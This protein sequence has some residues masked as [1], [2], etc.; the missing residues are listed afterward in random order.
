[1]GYGGGEAWL[2]FT[3]PVRGQ[4]SL[5]CPQENRG[6]VPLCSF[7]HRGVPQVYAEEEVRHD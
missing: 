6:D 5:T 1:M 7:L 3:P 2:R 4:G